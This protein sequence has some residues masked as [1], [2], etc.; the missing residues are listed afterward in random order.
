MATPQLIKKCS[1]NS[2]ARAAACLAAAFLIR[3][4][5]ATSRWRVI[6][7]PTLEALW[8]SDKPMI[9]CFW[10]GRL[11][12]M[13]FAWTRAQRFSMLISGHPDGLLIAGT[14]ARLGIRSEVGSS[15]RGGVEALRGLVR[16]LKGGGSI[17][18]TPDGPRGPR[19]RASTGAVAL[20]RLSGAALV[21]LTFS[22]RPRRIMNSWDS[23]LF[24][25][26]FSRGVFIWG[27]PMEVPPEADSTALD[28]MRLELEERMNAMTAEADLLCGHNPVPPAAESWESAS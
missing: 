3:L 19:M 18:I 15:S 11:M 28:T 23:F 22:C 24:A 8:N 2:L 26:P 21:P 27:E 4:V 13:P 25:W 12:M 16:I 1:R 9:V 5:W 7:A 14:V 17:G 10:H 6:K 20:A